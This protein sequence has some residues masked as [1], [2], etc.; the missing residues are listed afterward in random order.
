[1]YNIVAHQH[2]GQITV[3]SQ[4]GLTTFRVVLPERLGAESGS[5]A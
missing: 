3:R 1:V 5:P 2:R 4:P